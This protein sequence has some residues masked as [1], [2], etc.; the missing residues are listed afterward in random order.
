[1]VAACLALPSRERH[2]V[3]G[4]QS[5]D[6]HR[7]L[8]SD[9]AQYSPAGRAPVLLHGD[10]KV[11]DSMA[12]Y[13]YILERHPDAIGWPEDKRARAHAQSISA[14]MHSGFLGVRGE[15]PQNIRARRERSTLSLSNSCLAQIARIDEI[16]S[17]C[18]ARYGSRGRWLFGD[19]SW[20]TSCSCPLHFASCP[21]V[22][23]SASVM[24]YRGGDRTT[25]T[26]RC[27][28]ARREQRWTPL[29]APL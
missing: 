22:L 4:D 27:L 15:L 21:T 11:W 6:I 23:R 2:P 29:A 3:R 9:I 25:S 7:N 16:W 14:E 1:M 24:S 5:S 8:V 18:R 20:P 19:F 10:L 17:D 13:Q 12:I 26:S 28:R